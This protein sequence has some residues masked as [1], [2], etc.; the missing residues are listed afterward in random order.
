MGLRLLGGVGIRGG[1][2]K[3]LGGNARGETVRPTPGFG[4]IGKEGCRVGCAVDARTE[5]G[6][7][8]FEIRNAMFVTHGRGD[9]DH[10]GSGD[11]RDEA[12]STVRKAGSGA[13]DDREYDDT[14]KAEERESRADRYGVTARLDRVLSHEGLAAEVRQ[15]REKSNE[16]KLE[17]HEARTT[18]RVVAHENRR[19]VDEH[20]RE[21]HTVHG[22]RKLES[23]RRVHEPMLERT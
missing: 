4:H 10:Q 20:C 3:R 11:A 6:E 21:S 7:R 18:S 13:R 23:A 5:L 15:E 16:E 14:E 12:E 1:G 2:R 8:A 22:A 9:G 17:D 19:E